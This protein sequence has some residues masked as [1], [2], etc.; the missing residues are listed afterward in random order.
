MVATKF[1][2]MKS[3]NRNVAEFLGTIAVILG[4]AW[5]SSVALW[6][7]AYLMGDYAHNEG[8]L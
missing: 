8:A 5:G 6:K 1:G 2:P 3:D 7:T 4:F